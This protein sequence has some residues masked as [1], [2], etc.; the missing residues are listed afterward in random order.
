MNQAKVLSKNM[1]L[2][3]KRPR[4]PK[5]VRH[6]VKCV[7]T[8]G[9]IGARHQTGVCGNTAAVPQVLAHPWVVI[10]EGGPGGA[11]AGDCKGRVLRRARQEGPIWTQDGGKSKGHS[12]PRT[13]IGLDFFKIPGEASKEKEQQADT[14]VTVRDPV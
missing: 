10:T 7:S 9:E 5:Y 4:A 1:K 14:V 3:R 2:L 8:L 12:V 6:F 11:I 13:R